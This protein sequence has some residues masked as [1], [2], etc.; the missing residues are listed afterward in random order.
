MI[1]L[2]P[3]FAERVLNSLPMGLLAALLAWAFLRAC[4][5]QNSRARFAV[6][7]ATLLGVAAL[8]LLHQA[9]VRLAP[10][11]P[12]EFMIPSSWATVIFSAWALWFCFA[13]VRILVGLWNLRRLRVGSRPLTSRDCDPVLRETFASIESARVRLHVSE[14]QA[15]PAAIGFF[16]PMILLPHW[17]VQELPAEQLRAILLHELAHIQRADSWTNLAQKIIKA[18]FFFHP[19]VWWLDKR[20]CLE[21]EMACDDVVLSATGD[22]QR[23]AACL[24]SLAERSFLQRGLALAQAAVS[25]FC[26]TSLRVTEILNRTGR[27]NRAWTPVLGAFGALAVGFVA[28]LPHAPRLI[29]FQQPA[30]NLQGVAVAPRVPAAISKPT[31]EAPVVPARFRPPVATHRPERNKKLAVV[32]PP[33]HPAPEVVMAK[34]QQPPAEMFLVVRT[35]QYDGMGRALLSVTVWRVSVNPRTAPANQD[36]VLPKSI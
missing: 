25:R 33:V 24:I 28:I 10:G 22:P 35:A 3:L 13:L 5:P 27:R 36:G 34:A 1:S 7:F 4:G 16:R 31:I 32:K 20:L 6:W 29:A 17:T 26:E 30:G 11:K 23:Y 8:P 19:A 15:V 14:K 12:A 9:P 18:A 21:R 2:A